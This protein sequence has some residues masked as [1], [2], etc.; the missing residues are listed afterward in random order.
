MLVLMLACALSVA[1]CGGSPSR[2]VV[3]VERHPCPP[4]LPELSCRFDACPDDPATLGEL[5]RAYLECS[6]AMQCMAEYAGFVKRLHA[7]CEEG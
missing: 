1:S 4:A 5:Q 2:T 7:A 6:S 3:Q